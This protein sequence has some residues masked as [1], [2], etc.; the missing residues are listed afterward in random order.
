MLLEL[1]LACM[2]FSLGPL[3]R[4][5]HPACYVACSS[6]LFPIYTVE[7][8]YSWN[9]GTTLII[10][11]HFFPH[12]NKD[13]STDTHFL[14]PHW[15]F[16]LSFFLSSFPLTPH[17]PLFLSLLSSSRSLSLCILQLVILD[18]LGRLAESGADVHGRNGPHNHHINWH[19]LAKWPSNRLHNAHPLLV[20]RQSRQ[21]RKLWLWRATSTDSFREA[22]HL[23]P[24]WTCFLQQYSLLGWLGGGVCVQTLGGRSDRL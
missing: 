13:N 15:F 12:W 22:V 11:R 14:L 4:V 6:L 7:P 19:C 17:L 2:V 10:G 1:G 24:V 18:W 3:L 8:F 21:T 20:R 5:V 16:S 9:E 23:L